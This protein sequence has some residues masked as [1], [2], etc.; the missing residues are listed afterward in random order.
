MNNAQTT[1]YTVDGSNLSL[2]SN[3]LKKSVYG[4]VLVPDKKPLELSAVERKIFNTLLK[5]S[6]ETGRQTKGA[7]GDMWFSSTMKEIATR[8]GNPNK[9]NVQEY[10]ENCR[11]LMRVVLEFQSP[12]DKDND[13]AHAKIIKQIKL[14]HLVEKVD[15]VS[16]GNTTRVLWKFDS[17]MEPLLLNPERFAMLRFESITSLSSGHS[18]VLYEICARYKNTETG[19][20]GFKPWHFWVTALTGHVTTGPKRTKTYTE[21]RHF[22]NVVLKPAIAEINLKTEIDIELVVE[23]DGRT[24]TDIKFLTRRKARS[25]QSGVSFINESKPLDP[26]YQDL[27]SRASDLGL[28]AADI[29]KFQQ[30]FS[31]DAISQALDGLSVAL[32]N[33]DDDAEPIRSNRAYLKGV[34]ERMHGIQKAPKVAK[35]TTP[36]GSSEPAPGAQTQPSMKVGPIS[37]SKEKSELQTSFEALPE[38]VRQRFI[39]ECIDDIENRVKEGS[40]KMTDRMTLTALKNKDKPI[41]GIFLAPVLA[42]FTA[43][44]NQEEVA[45]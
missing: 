21:Y 37:N 30:K 16:E 44:Q 18:L 2:F 17:D 36:T 3:D 5:I 11:N 41:V 20:T 31:L 12:S 45:P 34:L 25:E 27:I 1:V 4:L 29:E 26:K 8:S 13:L 24:V 33:R 40:I 38:E 7:D 23:K 39:N 32:Q 6:M 10:T 9:F 14:R 22:N 15:F 35:A 19:S 28:L 43:S 42:K